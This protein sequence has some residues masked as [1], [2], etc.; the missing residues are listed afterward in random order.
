[1]TYDVVIATKDRSEALKISVPLILQQSIL[2]ERLI[3][4]DSGREH[5][6]VRSAVKEIVGSKVSLTIIHSQ[7]NLPQQ[8]NIGLEHVKSDVVF[9]PDDDSLWY[10]G[11][12]EAI[13]RIYRHDV[14]CEIG[15][16]CATWA[17]EPPPEADFLEVPKYRMKCSDRIKQ[18]LGY[19]RHQFE[20]FVC[21]NPMYVYGRKQWSNLIIPEWLSD[22]NAVPVE[23]MNGLCM[24]F[25][26]KVI[27]KYG[28]DADLGLHIGW[29]PC[30]DIAA[31]FA[32]TQELPVV[33]AC[34]AMVCHYTFPSA[35]TGGYLAGFITQLNRAYILCRYT[36]S[37]SPVRK[38]LG[39]SVYYK[40]MQYALG[41]HS[42]YG[43][44]RLQGHLHAMALTKRLLNTPIDDLQKCY[45][46]ICQNVLGDD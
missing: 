25:R 3:V 21:P 16:V 35:R 34:E 2:P 9:F 30:E 33:R 8:R 14:K 36:V 44:K 10:S 20:N 42:E 37:G 5:S 43:R 15:G 27:C 7:P 28:F 6:S 13:L 11:V 38:A 17:T 40:M 45:L 1:M 26:T 32:V 19:L 12:A 24:T 39:Y 31:S 41:I 29:A 18:K 23:Y 4:V 46:E 22:K